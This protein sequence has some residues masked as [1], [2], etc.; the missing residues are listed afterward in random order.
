[1]NRKF[2]KKI[3]IFRFLAI[4]VINYSGECKMSIFFLKTYCIL[5]DATNER[6]L[7]FIKLFIICMFFLVINYNYIIELT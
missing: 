3:F 5:H 2:S 4:F 7:V 1:M 6:F